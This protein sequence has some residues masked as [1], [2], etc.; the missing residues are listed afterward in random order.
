MNICVNSDFAFVFFN[1]I[2]NG[3]PTWAAILVGSVLTV[4]YTTIVSIFTSLISI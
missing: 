4:I 1:S 3:F 2:V